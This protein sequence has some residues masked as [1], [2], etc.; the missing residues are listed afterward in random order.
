MNIKHVLTVSDLSSAIYL[1]L[2]NLNLKK[3]MKF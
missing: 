2:K 1:I 3:M